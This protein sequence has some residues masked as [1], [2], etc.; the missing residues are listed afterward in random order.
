MPFIIAVSGNNCSGKSSVAHIIKKY[1]NFINVPIK[2]IEYNFLDVF[3][4]QPERWFLETQLSFL[5]SK[6]IE[7]DE[8]LQAEKNIVLDRSLSEDIEV[9]AKYWMDHLTIERKERDLYKALSQYILNKIPEPDLII[10]CKASVV[11]CE[12]RLKLRQERRFEKKFPKNYIADLADYYDRWLISIKHKPVIIFDSDLYDINKK[13]IENQ[14][15]KELE[16]IIITQS[17]R[18]DQLM[19]F[20]SSESAQPGEA[21]SRIFSLGGEAINLKTPL[22]IRKEI[23][24]PTIYIAAPFTAFAT[25]ETKTDDLFAKENYGTL[26]QQYKDFLT[27]IEEYFQSLKLDTFLPHHDINKWGDAKLSGDQV[28]VQIIPK[29]RYGKLMEKT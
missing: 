7:V 1:F 19:L 11:S 10:Y 9:Y 4:E 8:V 28:F 15:V 24:K 13:N 5:A 2:R 22:G 25:E 26:G 27:S 18:A 3:F 17:N 14:F 12:G 23:T 16:S 6:A 29:A 20:S 21:A